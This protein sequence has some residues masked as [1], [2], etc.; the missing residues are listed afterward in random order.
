MKNYIFDVKRQ[1]GE[2][3][4]FHTWKNTQRIY[5]AIFKIL[6]MKNY[7]FDVKRQ[8]GEKKVFHMQKENHIIH[9]RNVK[10]P[11]RPHLRIYLK[12]LFRFHPAWHMAGSFH[13]G[14]YAGFGSN[15]PK[16][17]PCLLEILS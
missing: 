12:G 3:I 8:R 11:I 9:T 13:K 14:G 4:V 15:L 5:L 17:S 1:R 16:I 2:N 6:R 7:I 10:P